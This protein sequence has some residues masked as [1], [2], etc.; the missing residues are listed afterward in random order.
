[1]LDTIFTLKPHFFFS[2]LF[3]ELIFPISELV[4]ETPTVSK[5]LEGLSFSNSGNG[6]K[7]ITLI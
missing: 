3:L 6:I 2:L 7:Q 4:A 5:N 1:M